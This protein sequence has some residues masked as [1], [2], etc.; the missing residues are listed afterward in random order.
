MAVPHEG[1]EDDHE[2]ADGGVSASFLALPAAT[3]RQ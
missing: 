2:L 3:R 1:V